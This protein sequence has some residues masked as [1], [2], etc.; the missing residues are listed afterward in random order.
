MN[1]IST[2]AAAL[3]P[4]ESRMTRHL[5]TVIG[6]CTRL[7]PHVVLCVFVAFM[8]IPLYLALVAA[9][10]DANAMMHAPLPIW[11]GTMLFANIKAVLSDG[12][13]ATGGEPVARMLC[14]SLLM[15]L[16][17]A[18]GKVILALFSAF[19]L[20]YFAFPMKKL[21]FALIF[22]TMI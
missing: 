17:I 9:S 12:L 1:S 11:P 21:C 14:N 3:Y 10:H 22:S 6:V 4:H 5:E 13:V 7:L 16:L 19:A 15:A 18:T 8:F 2:V 20:V